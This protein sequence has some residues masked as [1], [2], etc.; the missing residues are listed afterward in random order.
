MEE[1]DLENSS[2]LK[3]QTPIIDKDG[4]LKATDEFGN[5]AAGQNSVKVG[6]APYFLKI[7]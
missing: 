3:E 7:S 4:S 6:K 5:I 2:C 1:F